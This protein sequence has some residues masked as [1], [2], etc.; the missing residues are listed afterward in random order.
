MSD[1]ELKPNSTDSFVKVCQKL[2]ELRF[3]DTISWGILGKNIFSNPRLKASTRLFLFWLCS[4]VDQFYGYVTVWTK[5]ENAMLKLIEDCPQSF[6]K[7][8]EKIKNLR[9]DNK[10]NMIGDIFFNG[11]KFTLVRDDY[12]RIRNTFDFLAQYDKPETSL[13]EKFVRVLGELI[14]GNQ[15]E[16]GILKT[17]YFL[18]GWIFSNTRISSDPILNEL[19]GFREK[20][21]K[22]LWMFIMFLK[23]DPCVQNLFR[24]ALFEVYGNESGKALFSMW[25]DDSKFNPKEIELPGDMWNQRLFKA[26]LSELPTFLKQQPKR[27]ARELALRF[28]L[29][30]SVFDVT[31]EFGANKCKSMDC[32]PCPFGDN[33]LCHQGKEKL[34]SISKWLFPFYEKKA[35][36]I[37][38]QPDNC[39]ITKDYG[40]NL[41][42]REIDP[43]IVH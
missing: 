30:P 22:R 18:D 29:S 37:V 13:D 28:N 12:S 2:D 8:D 35:D 11:T 32:S 6:A 20:P 33:E 36:G 19:Q 21:R 16:S 34:C 42:T 14:A 9:K 31:F 39:P 10:G 38:C 27:T 26:L 17:A 3:M 5:G 7:V 15:G 24:E 41:C 40:K 4:I 43:E 1:E 25:N 23:R